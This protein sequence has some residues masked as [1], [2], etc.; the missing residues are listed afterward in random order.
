M[1]S[2]ADGGVVVMQND[3][4]GVSSRRANLSLEGGQQGQEH[5]HA[6]PLFAG[7][8]LQDA[9]EQGLADAVLDVSP[10]VAARCDEK[11]NELGVQYR[12]KILNR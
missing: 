10:A 4:E 7:V 11:L 9:A 3:P 5:E 2:S 1:L 12:T 8:G 6:E